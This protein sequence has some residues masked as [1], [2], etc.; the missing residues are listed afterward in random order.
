MSRRKA[1]SKRR[2]R[3]QR[4]RR[5][6]W[7]GG[8]LVVVVGV[9]AGILVLSPQPVQGESLPIEGANHVEMGQVPVSSGEPPA[10]GDHYAESAEPG[11]YEEPIEDGYLIHSLE[12]GYVIMWYD[13]GDLSEQGCIDLKTDIQSMIDEFDTFKVIGAP[14]EGMDTTLA[15]TS[16]GRILKL[17]TFDAGQVRGFIRTNRGRAP[18]PQGH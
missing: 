16:W 1:I 5:M 3:E 2:E 8:G 17:D 7:V 4:K 10:S 11:F 6:I 12:H 9:I 18:E 13:C 14:R 15:L